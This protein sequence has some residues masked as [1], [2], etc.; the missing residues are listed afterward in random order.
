MNSNKEKE[1]ERGR[2]ERRRERERE[3]ER[4]SIF[5]YYSTVLSDLSP[6]L[7]SSIKSTLLHPL[8][9]RHTDEETNLQ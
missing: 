5:S 9:D 7:V 1:K 6:I 8:S 3:R 4:E 2:P